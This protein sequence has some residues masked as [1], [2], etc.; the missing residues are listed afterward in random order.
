MKKQSE[1]TGQSSGLFIAI[2]GI[3]GSGTT[4]L[5]RNLL[6]E[7][8]TAGYNPLSTCEPSNS[9]VGAYIRKV[10]KQKSKLS[11]SDVLALLFAT[12]R[13][14]HYKSEIKP[15]I[16]KGRI[17]LSDRYLLSSLAYQTLEE[18]EQWVY[19]LNSRVPV[20]HLTIFIDID[21]ESAQARMAER[22][23][24]DFLEEVEYQK[25]IREKYKYFLAKYFPRAFI[26]DGRNSPEKLTEICLEKIFQLLRTS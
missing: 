25:I 11:S 13:I 18:E 15:A 26:V 14:I 21:I 2:E 16:G 17:V 22:T 3:D 4:T 12:D 6:A 9:E 24:R 23:D 1:N 5:I 20:P 10:L 7:L 8:S 19:T